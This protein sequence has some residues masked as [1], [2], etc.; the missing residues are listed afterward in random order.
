[1][2]TELQA[3]RKRNLSSKITR[4]CVCLVFL[5]FFPFFFFLSFMHHKI[6]FKKK[7]NKI[8]RCFLPQHVQ[9]TLKS[10]DVEDYTQILE[11]TTAPIQDRL[12]RIDGLVEVMRKTGE[13]IA[14]KSKKRTEPEIQEKEEKKEVAVMETFPFKIDPRPIRVNAVQLQYPNIIY[15]TKDYDDPIKTSVTNIQWGRS[16]GGYIGGMVPLRN[17]AIVVNSKDNYADNQIANIERGWN[18]F[19]ASRGLPESSVANPSVLRI[20]FGNIDGYR[21]ILQKAYQLVILALPEKEIGSQY[22]SQFTRILQSDKASNKACLIQCLLGRNASDPN[23]IKGSFDAIMAKIGNVLFQIDP[24]L[25]NGS[26]VINMN[27][28]WCVGME[29]SHRAEKPSAIIL[30]LSTAPL[31]G[32]LR[33]WHFTTHLNPSRK[34]VIT[35]EAASTLM[36]DALKMAVENVGSRNLP[37]NIIF[38]RGGMPDNRLHELYSK[39]VVGVARGI[40]RFKG[41]FEKTDENVKKWKCKL[42]YVVRCKNVLD[43]FGQLQEGGRVG[44]IESPAVI[45]DGVTSER[46]VVIQQH[47]Q[48]KKVTNNIHRFWDFYVWPY[49]LKKEESKTRPSRYVVLRDD[50]GLAKKGGTFDLFQ[51]I[52]SL[53]Y[54]YVFSIPFPRY[55]GPTASPGPLQYAK[56]YAE[57]FS[58]MIFKADKSIDMLKRSNKLINQPQVSVP[59]QDNETTN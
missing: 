31:E 26:K 51:L 47:K 37:E 55:M 44:P 56:H 12:H 43:R 9:L 15:M 57:R 8:G 14:S 4:V 30:A 35:L 45:F 27:K 49:H 17:W 1:M 3:H 59:V 11:K 52:Y 23:V 16:G 10:D 58:Q 46:Y 13:R 18:S 33:S 36:F 39:E 29:L 20:D 24:N 2:R 5:H 50:I 28:T 19:V 48:K 25:P 32:S 40:N 22:K 21:A 34:D 7:K 41:L 42:T 38:L 54:T 53:S 6:F